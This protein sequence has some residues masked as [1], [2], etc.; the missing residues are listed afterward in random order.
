MKQIVTKAILKKFKTKCEKLS[1]SIQDIAD[2]CSIES[3]DSNNP[4]ATEM[5]ESLWAAQMSINEAQDILE[6]W[7]L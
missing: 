3:D 5:A 7:L 4:G 6:E 1:D 2:K